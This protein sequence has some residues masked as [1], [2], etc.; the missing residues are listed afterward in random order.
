MRSQWACYRFLQR[1]GRDVSLV[2]GGQ[3][4][5]GDDLLLTPLIYEQHRQSGHRVVVGTRTAELFEHNPA[6]AGCTVPDH[7]LH[8]WLGA[9]GVFVSM[10][11]YD[12]W[13]P[14]DAVLGQPQQHIVR[15]MACSG[16]LPTPASLDPRI[17]LTAAEL[18][19]GG[20]SRTKILFQTSSDVI[21]KPNKQWFPERFTAVAHRLAAAGYAVAQV[22]KM[23]DAPLRVGED[24]RGTRSIRELAALIAN[25][26]VL[27]GLVGLMMHLARAVGCPAV[28]IY[29][30]REAPWQS[31]YP[32]NENLAS[33]VPCAPCWYWQ[34]CDYGRECMKGIT[35]DD[36]HAAALR[37]L[38][39]PR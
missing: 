18:A 30:G 19:G 33:A 37:V 34:R 39:R 11:V 29:G 15:E 7:G 4:G 6:V 1:F 36:V 24:F 2:I 17:Y 8:R 22:G 38:A 9:Y 20:R 31:G 28:V 3:G 10:P 26:T 27:V 23:T 12:G 35:V 14:N 21:G 5:I 32:E 13:Y 16:H 25:A